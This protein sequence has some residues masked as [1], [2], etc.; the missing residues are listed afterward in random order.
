MGGAEVIHGPSPVSGARSLAPRAEAGALLLACA[1]YLA[2]ASLRAVDQTYP[3]FD[4]VAYL[5]LGNQVRALGGP[6]KLWG[7]LFAGRFTEANRHPLYLAILSCFARPVPAFHRE[8]QALSVALGLVALL[9]CWWVARRHV[10]RGAAAVLAL[11]LA[12]NGT[13]VAVAG[14]ETCEPL[15]VA[16]WAQAVGAILDGGRSAR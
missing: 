6:L 14:R 1:V 12:A 7:A 4:D 10:G 13:F 5:D 15:L 2:L 8:A 11:F 16:V 9:S 3:Y